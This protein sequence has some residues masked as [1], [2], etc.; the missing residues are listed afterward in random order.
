MRVTVQRTIMIRDHSRKTLLLLLDGGSS[1]KGR[2][3]MWLTDSGFVTWEANDVGHAIEEISDFTVKRRPDVVLL[4][5]AALPECFDTFRS[6][7]E[8]TPDGN[9]VSILALSDSNTPPEMKPFVA[10]NFDQLRTIMGTGV[11]ASTPA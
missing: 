8:I 9:N 3:R 4:E 6:T 11:Q 5:V 1:I 10:R 2:V 7:F